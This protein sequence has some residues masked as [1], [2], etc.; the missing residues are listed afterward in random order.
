MGFPDGGV[1]DAW[2]RI[3]REIDRAGLLADKEHMRPVLAAIGRF[4]DTA[5]SIWPKR[6][7][8]CRYP[9]DIGIVRVNADLANE[10]G[11]GEADVL[12]GHAGIGA[13]VHAITVG[14][15]DADRGF[16]GA[17][18][19]H[20]GIGRGD[21]QGADCARREKAIGDMDA[22]RCRHRP[23]SRHHPRSRRSR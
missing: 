5:F 8:E 7:P 12:P 23:F 6:M 13:L 18:V 11:I 19:D 20:I 21:R 3:E 1:E 15:I 14:N 10:A 2:V 9:D 4:E 17:G 16:A 22:S